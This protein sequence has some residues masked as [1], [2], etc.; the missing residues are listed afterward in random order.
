[1]KHLYSS[2]FFTILPFIFF[3]QARIVL[4][5]G[6]ITLQNGASLV[7]QNSDPNAVTTLNAAS[8]ILI[9]DM[10]SRLRWHIGSTAASYNIPF[11]YEDVLIPLSFSTSDAVGTGYFDLSTYHVPTWKNS[12][13]LPPSVDNINSE[14]GDNSGHVVDRFWR[15]D[16]HDYIT[17]PNLGKLNLSYVDAEWNA[18]GNLISE[19]GLKAQRWNSSMNTWSDFA[20]S[21]IDDAVNN[22]V[23]LS[24]VS[25]SDLFEWWTLVDENFPLSPTAVS[26]NNPPMDRNKVLPGSQATGVMIYP[27]PVVNTLTIYPGTSGASELELF[28]AAGRKLYRQLITGNVEK[29]NLSR[30]PAG[31]YV[32]QLVKGNTKWSYKIIKQ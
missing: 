30:M 24:S 2:F 8:G 13:Y 28:D 11:K 1:M 19:A 26:R 25:A 16:A 4:N 12:D 17:K 9:N 3:A 27:N 5:G 31:S 21:G 20:P 23:P 22:K 14:D 18:T 10:Q 7:V 6:T 29:I 15:I 32:L